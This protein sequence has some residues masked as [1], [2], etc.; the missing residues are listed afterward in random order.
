MTAAATDARN[1]RLEHGGGERGRTRSGVAPRIASS[2]PAISRRASASANAARARRRTSGW[3]VGGARHGPREREV[4]HAAR[5]VLPDRAGGEHEREPVAAAR[6]RR[7]RVRED[8]EHRARARTARPARRAASGSRAAG[9][10]APTTSVRVH[11]RTSRR[12]AA[13]QPL[14]PA[15]LGR[16]LDHRHAG[17]EQRREQPRGAG[18]VG[19]GEARVGRHPL[20]VRRARGRGELRE[21]RGGHA[22]PA[23]RATAARAAR[24]RWPR[25]RARSPCSRCG[26]S[27][28][29]RRACRRARP[30]RAGAS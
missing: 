15:F 1:R 17:A 14:E 22:P 6:D 13:E 3:H 9:A 24:A 30:R 29:T 20:V 7:E 12:R 18:V 25:R 8:R 26:P 4:Q 11:E 28:R 19:D 5:D 2:A 27:A 23:R 16:R 10:A 21:A